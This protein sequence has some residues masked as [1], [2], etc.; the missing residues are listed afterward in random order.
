MVCELKGW[1]SDTHGALWT[2]SSEKVHQLQLKR[3]DKG[4][5]S[6]PVGQKMYRVAK[7]KGGK[8]GKIL[9][10]R[11]SSRLEGWHWSHDFGTE[12]CKEEESNI[13]SSKADHHQEGDH[14]F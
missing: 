12:V 2:D 7:K 11:G 10:I 6:D 3:I 4:L 8:P 13:N 9:W 5:Y 14:S 1:T